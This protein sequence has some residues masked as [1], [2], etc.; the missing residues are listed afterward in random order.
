MVRHVLLG[1]GI[2]SR[3]LGDSCVMCQVCPVVHKRVVLGSKSVARR[4]V[5]LMPMVL[6]CCGLSCSP[7]MSM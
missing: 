1:L 3:L 5:G 2:S 4:G 6:F 7:P